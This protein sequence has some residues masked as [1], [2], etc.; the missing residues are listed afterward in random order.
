MKKFAADC[1]LKLEITEEGGIHT[2]KFTQPP[3]GGYLATIRTHSIKPHPKNTSPGA[4]S[5]LFFYLISGIRNYELTHYL[6]ND[7]APHHYAKLYRC[8]DRHRRERYLAEIYELGTES[9]GA[10]LVSKEDYE[11]VS[12]QIKETQQAH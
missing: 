7:E 10:F 1:G 9:G 5:R 2:Y 4:I 11:R 6:L 12:S 3:M 8:I